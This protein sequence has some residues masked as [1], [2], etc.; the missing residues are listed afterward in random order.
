MCTNNHQN[1]W[2]LKEPEVGFTECLVVQTCPATL[3]LQTDLWLKENLSTNLVVTMAVVEHGLWWFQMSFSTKVMVHPLLGP[4]NPIQ[5]QFVENYVIVQNQ[6]VENSM[7]APRAG[8]SQ[9]IRHQQK[10]LACALIR[11]LENIIIIQIEKVSSVFLFRGY[12]NPHWS[13]SN[14]G[15]GSMPHTFST[16]MAVH[17]FYKMVLAFFLR[18]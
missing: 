14:N 16:N 13:R 4:K 17:I 3:V 7:S 10:T 15:G 8:N 11:S 1:E 18:T 12:V 5:N 2:G 9:Q 6:L